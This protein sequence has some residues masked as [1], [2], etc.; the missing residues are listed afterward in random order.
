[1]KTQ[2]SLVLLLANSLIGLA[3]AVWINVFTGSD[4]IDW[5][6]AVGLYHYRGYILLVFVVLSLVLLVLIFRHERSGENAIPA[7]EVPEDEARRASREFL[8]DLVERYQTRYR[9][10]LDGRFEISLLVSENLGSTATQQFDEEFS[11]NAHT[12]EA[13]QYIIERFERQGRLLIV[14]SPGAGK[15]VLLLKLA[16]HL[17]EKAGREPSEPLPV[18]FNLASWSSDYKR[19]DDWLK[20]ALTQ[21]YGLSSDFAEMMLRERRITFLLDG[22]DE[23]ARNEE[24]AHAAQVRAECLAA[25]NKSLYDGAMNVVICCRREEFAEMG[26][27][28]AAEAP[29]AAKVAIQDL[30]GG[31]IDLALIRAGN[32]DKDR[33]AAQNLLAALGQDPNGVYQQVLTTPFYF[34]LALQVFDFSK[35]PAIPAPDKETLEANLVAGF[36][37]KKIRITEN[38]LQF[39]HGHTLAWLAWLADFLEH[40]QQ[41]TFELAELQPDAVKKP[42][43]N[44]V[45][46]RVVGGLLGGLLSGLVAGAVYGILVGVI[47][48]MLGGDDDVDT[49]DLS[50]WTFSPLTRLSSWKRIVKRGVLIGV[51][52]GILL[53]ILLKAYEL[54]Y[55][56]SVQRMVFMVVCCSLTGGVY[57]VYLGFVDACRR[58]LPFAK[59]ESP[60]QRLRAGIVFNALPIGCFASQFAITLRI[61]GD[62]KIGWLQIMICFVGGAVAGFSN[63][64]LYKH[65]LLR[66]CLT[67]EGAMPARYVAFLHY[68]S[69]LSILE[70]DGGQ[71]RFRHQNLQDFFAQ[72]A[73]DNRRM[74]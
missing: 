1:M 25:L 36:V 46:N 22:L 40:R 19:F 42:W 23:L 29:V 33:F 68:A 55:P 18:I 37:E 6:K 7:A 5:L 8:K 62:M 16:L 73:L 70:Q 28:A 61:F 67:W 14:G 21:G 15:T 41:V 64:A 51:S 47:V 3:L 66:W 57:G 49:E 35:P 65:C 12:G 74:S 13:A 44:K 69:A 72:R 56:G 39:S 52:L 11:A 71:W 50:R 30:T 34:T 45:V 9:N 32:S 43:L 38:A 20:A 24:P 2:R 53:S 59:L 4:L 26:T 48:A 17:A 63:S 10:K 27:Q 58:I 60:Y 31:Q 54:M